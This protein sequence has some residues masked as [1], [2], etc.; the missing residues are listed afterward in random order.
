MKIPIFPTDISNLTACIPDQRPCSMH[1]PQNIKFLI[2][3]T[4]KNR[5]KWLKNGKKSSKTA[6][7][8]QKS[9]NTAKNGQKSSK[10][11]KNW[12]NQNENLI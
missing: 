10:I 9:T 7:N 6:K 12:Q 5:Q 3:K 2:G 1:M 8:G 4:A 11:D